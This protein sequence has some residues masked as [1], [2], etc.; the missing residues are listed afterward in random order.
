M[1]KLIL[2]FLLFAI[3]VHAQHRSL[4][5]AQQ[6]GTGD[7]ALTTHGVMIG[8]GISPVFVLSPGDSL[9]VLTSLG[10][11]FDPVW[12]PASGGGGIDS[13]HNILNQKNA[14]QTGSFRINGS[15]STGGNDTAAFFVARG[16]GAGGAAFGTTGVLNS[17]S[18]SNG[19]LLIGN[20]GG[21]P[22]A[23]LITPGA[24]IN[25]TNSPG[26]ITISATVDS[27]GTGFIRNQNTSPQLP[28]R[29]YIEDDTAITANYIQ[30]EIKDSTT[31]SSANVENIGL[32]VTDNGANTGTNSNN[33]ALFISA[34]G[35]TFNNDIGGPNWGISDAGRLT[36]GIPLTVPNGGTGL[37]SATAYAPIVGGTT[38]TGAFQVA[39]SGM[40]NSGYVLTST[41]SSSL[42]TWQAA[43]GGGDDSIPNAL[44]WNSTSQQTS[45][46]FNIDGNGSIGTN[47]FV[48]RT[49]T[50]AASYYGNI[51]FGDP[52]DDGPLVSANRGNLVGG[53]KVTVRGKYGVTIGDNI[54]DSANQS[55]VIGG[56]IIVGNTIDEALVVG[57]LL[58][59]P[60]ESGNGIGLVVL[61]QNALDS[62]SNTFLF[63][64]GSV[65][66]ITTVPN[67]AIFRASG[68]LL[69]HDNVAQAIDS[70]LTFRNDSLAINGNIIYPSSGG[71]GASQPFDTLNVGGSNPIALSAG[72]AW[73]LDSIN[74]GAGQIRSAT[75]GFA[76]YDDT[77]ATPAL[78]LAGGTLNTIG[79]FG[80]G[81]SLGNGV[82]DGGTLCS[83]ISDGI[84][85]G[86]NNNTAVTG[87]IGS[88]GIDT[89]FAATVISGTAYG[90]NSI[91]IGSGGTA[92]FNNS[93]VIAASNLY[94]AQD[95]ASAQLVTSSGDSTNM[96]TN[97]SGVPTLTLTPAGTIGS[98][99]QQLT[100]PTGL[101]RDSAIYPGTNNGWVLTDV[102][103]MSAWAAPTGGVTSISGSGGTTG[104][105]LTGGPITSSGTLTLGGTL[106]IANGGTGS[107]TVT[108]VNQFF[109]N[110]TGG[111]AP[112]FRAIVSGDVPT[113]NQN[114]SGTAAGLSA[115]L[116]I[117][118]G[119]TGLTTTSQNFVFAGPSSGSGAPSWRTLVAGDI[120]SLSGSYVTTFT[121]GSTGLTPVSG[122]SGAISLAG[123]LVAANGGTGAGAF[124]SGSIPYIGASGVYQQDNANFSWND[125]S[126]ILE[127]G[128][129]STGTV[130]PHSV[131]NMTGN[132]NT[133]IQ[134]TIQNMSSGN[135]ASSDFVATANNGTDSTYYVDLG[136][137]GSGFSQAAQNLGKADDSYLYAQNGNLDLFAA[138]AGDSVVLA[139]GGST[140]SK[141]ALT[142]NG[143]QQVTFS[144]YGVG[145]L[146]TST[147]GLVS[148]V[149]PGSSGT[150]LTS[151]GATSNPTWQAVS[152]SFSGLTTNGVMYAT[153]SSVIATTAAGNNGQFLGTVNG[154]T[155]QYT[156]TLSSLGTA[157]TS[158]L[159]L[160]LR[161]SLA[162]T[163]GSQA[164]SPRLEFDGNGWGTTNSTSHLEQ[165]WAEVIPVQGATQANSLWSL[166]A[167]INSR[168]AMTELTIDTLGIMNLGSSANAKY[169]INGT[170]VL[171]ATTLGSG[172]TASSLSTV[173]TTLALGIASGSILTV[174]NQGQ[175]NSS[176]AN[177]GMLL[178][179]SFTATVGVT[180]QWPGLLTFKGT[181]WKSNTTAA[182][183]TD[184]GILQFQPLTGATVTSGQW[185]FYSNINGTGNV[186]NFTIASNGDATI[187]D[188]ILSSNSIGTI[189]PDGTGVTSASASGSDVDG[190]ITF[191]TAINTSGSIVVNY[192][193]AYA[194]APTAMISIYSSTMPL[195]GNTI[196]GVSQAAGSFTISF[197]ATVVQTNAKILYHVIK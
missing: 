103:G 88:P 155:P 151:N 143:T 30:S 126:Q 180:E 134:A 64:D 118:S 157:N 163:A 105:T 1:K 140:I 178:N 2:L 141:Q 18:L 67:Q 79:N 52:G 57:T 177:I 130:L 13:T 101:I 72:S 154:A 26:A 89:T 10:A 5:G 25:I 86:G 7:S 120:P 117:A 144:Q 82:L 156:S 28:G 175:G 92:N 8:E 40:S 81:V 68:G 51:I 142:I 11:G 129:V 148:A 133:Y 41:G 139:T 44:I 188:H 109:A 112:A 60:T 138:T 183:Q 186:V 125:A 63:S 78:T 93:I 189:T 111:S 137:N 94:G 74:L 153:S 17:V 100:Y 59:V 80:S 197:S 116:V 77:T 173:G 124:T 24:G 145:A 32:F 48:F 150:V 168:A 27:S 164:Y 73:I 146:C 127:L 131:L 54:I 160:K 99:G 176:S 53:S 97:P 90:S 6:A 37:A 15:G 98:D 115:T 169:E 69:F 158:Y 39:N 91:N 166:S 49:G 65:Q 152:P 195:S 170:S 113:L 96:Y 87:V 119:G 123:I 185:V 136:I 85:Y 14:L 36:L 149:T 83:V 172:I 104:L 135:T 33:V 23:A 20:S 76:L 132:A 184:L 108:G 66:T 192:G 75:N 70:G 46:N 187:A 102:G 84:I 56:N 107:A 16:F 95:Y 167:E 194:S 179:N 9:Y 182:S 3:Q 122:T 106:A 165:W 128:P 43:G 42:P 34:T 162:A 55:A 191:T 22:T 38:T 21:I 31:S 114:T 19:Q 110:T 50:A 35:G 45:A 29:F 4:L 62:N 159:G 61:G 190:T 71:R 196:S 174:N 58:R 121:G 193:T 12:E 171:S 181:A 147:S 161:D 47:M